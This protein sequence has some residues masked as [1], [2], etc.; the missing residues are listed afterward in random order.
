MIIDKAKLANWKVLVVD[1]EPDSLEVVSRVLRFY[2]AK[3]YSAESG[4]QAL[5]LAREFELTFILSDLSMPEMDGW[6]L[7]ALLHES[8][9]TRDIP[10][11]AL[12]AHAMKGDRERA[13]EKG[14]HHY[15]TKPLSP[16]TFLED[17]LKLFSELQ[18]TQV[19][20]EP[21]AAVMADQMVG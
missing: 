12:T 19:L 3:V 9:R 8:V 21:L 5:K 17:L 16:F 2:G 1:D 7:L 14:F 11:I 10:V 20:P 4:E 15:L 6:T 13:I 18:T